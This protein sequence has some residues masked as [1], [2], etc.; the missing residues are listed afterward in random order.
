MTAVEPVLL[1]KG[2]SLSYFVSLATDPLAM[3]RTLHRAYGPFVLLQYPWMRRSRLATFSCIANAELYRAVF[4]APEVW[5]GVKI[6]F[7]GI[8]GHA[9]DRL[10]MGMTRLR[11]A[12]HAHYRR[13]LALPLSRPAV[14][15]MSR[16]MA[17][18]AEKEVSSW[19]R[20]VLIDLLALTE[21][22]SLELAIKLLFG[23][24]RDR[25][26]PIANMITKG[27]AASR[28]L[29]G[30]EFVSWLT[31]AAKQER[32]ILDWAKQKCG[33]L[34][35]KDI[36][37][38][39]VNSPD[40]T[41]QPPS[42]AIIGGI[43]S[44][45]FGATYETC[46]NGLAWTLIMVAQHRQIAGPL[47][48]EIIGVLGGGPPDRIDALPL[49]NGVIKEAM[50][51]FPPVP[52]QY[53]KSTVATELAGT[54]IAAGTRLL[55]SIYLINRNP[56]LY[57]QPDRFRPERWESLDPSPY[58]YTVFGAGNRMC[59][60]FIFATQMMKISLAAILSRYRVTIAKNARID[61]R[62]RIALSPYPSVPVIL[63]DIDESPDHSPIS[64]GIH[65]LVDVAGLN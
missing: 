55:A 45:V 61:Y 51:I 1:G 52:L 42:P 48:E 63:R 23:E 50:R 26:L 4:T 43:L 17:A 12:R 28:L 3:T 20:N 53:R 37:S 2:K 34:D 13:I 5:R 15:A 65:K 40:E 19:P 38:I 22:L 39:I 30:R 9:S 60:G 54:Y 32:A 10:T 7:R 56:D 31:V 14:L 62:T 57:C 21:R 44:F 35:A 58:D 27:V 59:P 41:G 24:E 6:N 11:G 29:P 16:G 64:G 25:A 46:R 8:K 47:A 33:H 49:L 18:A 36:L